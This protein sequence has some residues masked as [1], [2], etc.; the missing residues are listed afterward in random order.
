MKDIYDRAKNVV[1]WLG[2]DAGFAANAI[3][4]IQR[5]ARIAREERDYTVQEYPIIPYEPK[6]NPRDDLPAL[7]DEIWDLID[8]FYENVWFR[9]IG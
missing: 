3:S 2:E 4:L 9:R 6:R 7:E 5:V 1:I 8:L